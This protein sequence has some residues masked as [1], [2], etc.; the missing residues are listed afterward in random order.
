[1][2]SSL[3]NIKTLPLFRIRRV[4]STVA[5]AWYIIFE[6]RRS[7]F[8]YNAMNDIVTT[9]FFI[10]TA[11]KFK[12]SAQLNVYSRFTFKSDTHLCRTWGNSAPKWSELKNKSQVL[13]LQYN[14]SHEWD[15]KTYNTDFITPIETILNSSEVHFTEVPYVHIRN[16]DSG[17]TNQDMGRIHPTSKVG[18]ILPVGR[19]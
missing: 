6:C 16:Y 19:I 5:C 9:S 7:C 12:N 17:I 13:L 18:Y 15:R 3:T 2:F 11:C 1:M 10:V 4:A 8:D 14:S